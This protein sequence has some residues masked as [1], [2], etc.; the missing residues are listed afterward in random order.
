MPITAVSKQWERELDVEQWLRADFHAIRTPSGALSDG[1][2]QFKRSRWPTWNRCL[3]A[4][5]RT[6][7]AVAL[8]STPMGV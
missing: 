8:L 4:S 1:N 3:P 6:I 7:A 5:P 2:Q